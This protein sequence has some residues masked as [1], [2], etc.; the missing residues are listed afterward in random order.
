VPDYSTLA[1]FYNSQNIKMSKG[2]LNASVE[3]QVL[4]LTPLQAWTEGLN[5]STLDVP[6]MSLSPNPV[7]VK[8]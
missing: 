3:S 4:H 7:F 6:P 8:N 5:E 2:Y 1:T